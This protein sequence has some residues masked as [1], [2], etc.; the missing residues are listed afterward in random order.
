ML[1]DAHWRAGSGASGQGL[2]RLQGAAQR[3]AVGGHYL[4]RP[5]QV[6]QRHPVQELAPRNAAVRYQV[7]TALR[8]AGKSGRQVDPRE[9]A[10]HGDVPAEELVAYGQDLDVARQWGNQR[11]KD[12][13]AVLAR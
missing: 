11:G 3:R 6:L 9:K 13:G 7:A 2:R 10:G 12:P 1:A 4:D 5:G 8:Q